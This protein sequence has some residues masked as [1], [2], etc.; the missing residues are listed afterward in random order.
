MNRLKLFYGD[1]L[2]VEEIGT[3]FFDYPTFNKQSPIEKSMVS[4]PFCPKIRFKAFSDGTM[5]IYR[6]AR[7]A[8]TGTPL[9]IATIACALLERDENRRL[10]N[11]NYSRQM[12]LIIF[13]F[14]R[15]KNYVKRE[16]PEKVGKELQRLIEDV[17]F[18]LKVKIQQSG[19][20]AYDE[21]E[22]V[23][24]PEKVFDSSFNWVIC[25]TSR[26]GIQEKVRQREQELVNDRD[27][28]NPQI[29]REKAR[30]RA[31]HYMGLLE[32]FC[33]FSY[34]RDRPKSYLMVDGLIYPYRKI[35]GLFGISYENYKSTI[36]R[37]VGF[38]KHPRDIPYEAFQQI[39]IMKFGEYLH[40][41]GQPSEVELEENKQKVIETQWERDRFRFALLRFRIRGQEISPNPIGIVKL[42]ISPEHEEIQE[43]V[44]SVLYENLPWP[45]DRRRIYNEPYPIELTEKVAKAYLPSESRVTGLVYSIVGGIE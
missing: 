21:E 3:H 14:E 16:L 17:K 18:Q 36:S 4:R 10:T 38:I 20:K 28:Y 33:S 15:Y 8:Y 26:R 27:L 13:P 32:F 9:F 35:S 45:T 34:L 29:I 19:G 11:T 30:A 43:I 40:W 25:D 6:V 44:E 12:N 24:E 39:P 7:A 1:F 2:E 41:I 22:F 5:K 37:I 31:R 23:K 42:Q